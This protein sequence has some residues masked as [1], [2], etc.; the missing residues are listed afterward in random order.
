LFDKHFDM[1]KTTDR[2]QLFNSSLFEKNQ[3]THIFIKRAVI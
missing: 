3:K 2:Q 1:I